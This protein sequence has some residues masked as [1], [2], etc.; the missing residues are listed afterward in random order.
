MLAYNNTKNASIGHILL[1]INYEYHLRMSFKDETN[2]YLKSYF[3]NKLTNKL[4]K[5]REICYQN[6]FYTQKL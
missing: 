5:L 4:R 1:K 6:L 3:A 2:S